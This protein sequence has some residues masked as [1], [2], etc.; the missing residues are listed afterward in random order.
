VQPR[1]S[2]DAWARLPCQVRSLRLSLEKLFRPLQRR[3]GRGARWWAP[4]RSGLWPA[5]RPSHPSP[6]GS[7]DGAWLF[8]TESQAARQ[9]P[10]SLAATLAP[11]CLEGSTVEK[12]RH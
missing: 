5:S 10:L 6:A 2:R 7:R 8:H 3:R 9:W 11:Q 4:D 12:L 1:S